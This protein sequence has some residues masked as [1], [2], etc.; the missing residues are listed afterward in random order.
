MVDLT[1]DEHGRIQGPAAGPGPRPLRA[2]VQDLAHRARARRSGP[3]SQIAT[4]DP[5]HGYKN[6]ID[7]QLG[8]RPRR[9]GR[10]PRRQARH[11]GRRRGPPPGAAGHQRPPRP[12]ATTRCTGSGTSCA[13]ATRTSPTGN[14]P[15]STRRSPP[16]SE[17]VEVEVAWRCAQQ[18]RSAYHQDSHAAG[19]AIAEKILDSFTSCPI[20]EVARLGRTLK[21]WRSEFLGYFDTNGAN[22]G[23][24]EAINGLIE[25]HRRIARG[26]RNRDNYRLRISSRVQAHR[27]SVAQKPSSRRAVVVRLCSSSSASAVRNASSACSSLVTSPTTVAW[28]VLS[29][30]CSATHAA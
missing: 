23:G 29:A 3:G 27:G 20:P 17:H 26:F 14:A 11:A 16:T 4:L 21:Q 10:L 19:R 1:R 12:H 2:G 8:G 5:F 9:P 30:R 6:A 7:D 15:G 25:L 24:T 18:V 13:P 28:R 22:N